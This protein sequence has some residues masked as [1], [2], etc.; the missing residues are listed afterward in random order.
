MI[1]IQLR[2]V[3]MSVWAFLTGEIFLKSQGLNGILRDLEEAQLTHLT[4]SLMLNEVLKGL[5]FL[6][7]KD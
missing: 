6:M 7:S 2:Q 4:D 5:D 3:K 1:V